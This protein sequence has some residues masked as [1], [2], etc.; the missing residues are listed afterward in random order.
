M[1]SAR[2]LLP[3]L[4]LLGAF[5]GATAGAARAN[6][7]PTG[8]TLLA[9]PV[10]EDAA[11]GA[12]IGTL[13]ATDPDA[14]DTHVFELID[15]PVVPLVIDGDRLRLDGALDYE[16]LA[17]V[18]VAV[19]ARDQGGLAYEGA[20]HFDVL[21]VNEPPSAVTL[22][23][24][25]VREGALPGTVVGTL[26]AVDEDADEAWSFSL[27]TDGSVP[28]RL[29]AG[30]TQV[31]VSRALDFETAPAWTL[32]VTVTDRGGN[33][34][35]LPLLIH[36]LDDPEAPT[37]IAV[38]PGR[39]A[40]DAGSGALVGDVVVT[41]PDAGDHAVV[42]LLDGAGGAVTLSN[43]QIRLARTVDH[44]ATPTLTIRLRAVDTTGRALE[45]VVVLLVDDVNEPP[46]GLTLTPSSVDEG[47]AIGS[48]V[49]LLDSDD[50]DEGDD[51][52]Y[53]LAQNDG[54]HLAVDGHRLIVAKV[55]DYEQSDRIHIR[56]RAVDRGGL[57][58]E[59]SWQI[60]VRDVNEPPTGIAFSPAPVR[61]NSPPHQQLGQPVA[62][63]DPDR[64][65]HF[66]WELVD[67]AGGAFYLANNQL[68]TARSLDYEARPWLVTLRV[69]DHGGLS[70]ERELEVPVTDVN[71]PPTDVALD[72]ASVAENEPAGA[73]V[74]ALAPVGDPDEGDLW[75]YSLVSTGGGRFAIDGDRLVT[76]MALDHEAPLNA[77]TVRVRVTDRGGLSAER[78]FDVV[79]DDVNEPPTGVGVS[80]AMVAENAPIGSSA[81]TLLALGDPDFGDEHA[82]ELLDDA[83]AFAVSG[84]HLVTTRALDF[85]LEPALTL[86]VRCTDGAGHAVEGAVTVQVGDVNE[87]PLEVA[88]AGGSV[89]ENAPAGTVVGA[90]TTVGDPDVGEV[91]A[92]S[93]TSDPGLAF[94][95][96]GSELVTT[97]PLDHEA[98]ATL[99][100]GVQAVDHGGLSVAGRF[101]VTVLDRNDPPRITRTAFALTPIDEDALDSPG[102]SV[103]AVLTHLG[104]LDDDG[105]GALSGVA[106]RAGSVAGGEV[107][108][109]F[110]GGVWRPLGADVRVLAAGVGTRLRFAPDAD[111]NGTLPAA[112]V[113]W[114]WDGTAAADGDAL[115]DVPTGV[116][117]AF[118]AQAAAVGVTVVAID[119]APVV[120]APEDPVAAWQHV[121]V[122]FGASVADVDAEELEVT[123][124]AE[125]GVV[126][127]AEAPGALV[128][129][130]AQ[131]TASVTLRGSTEALSAALARV[132]FEPAAGFVGDAVVR[133]VA[134]DLGGT[135]LGGPLVTTRAVTIAVAAAP[136]V[137]LLR[138]EA[139][140]VDGGIDPLGTLPSGVPLTLVYRLRNVGAAP[141]GV[142]AIDVATASTS[143][144]TA[145]VTVAPPAVVPPGAEGTV[146]VTVVPAGAGPFEVTLAF[147][148][149][150][151]DE[152]LT[153]IVARGEAAPAALLELTYRGETV[154][155][156]VTADLGAF[157]VAEEVK[158]L[159]WV[160]NAGAAVLQLASVRVDAIDGCRLTVEP[161][162]GTLSPGGEEL[163]RARVRAPRAGPF[164]FS[165]AIESNDPRGVRRF[166]LRGIAG[167][168]GAVRIGVTRLPG[169]PIASGG[170][171]DVGWLD[172]GGAPRSWTWRIANL[173]LAPVALEAPVVEASEGVTATLSLDRR[174][175]AP[176]EA[177]S[178]SAR[179]V[180]SAAGPVSV[181]LVVPSANL[182]PAKRLAWT[183]TGE[184][185]TEAAARPRFWRAGV[186]LVGGVDDVGAAVIG[187]PLAVA[188]VL[189]NAG[190]AA[191]AIDGAARLEA[192]EG[193][194]GRVPASP[195][196]AL[197]PGAA[198]MV[199]VE[200]TPAARGALGATLTVAGSGGGRAEVRLEGQGLDAGV[201]L[202]F[203]GDVV[204]D[205]GASWALPE[206]VS[207][208]TMT[209]AVTV[210]NPGVV[211]LVVGAPTW[212]GGAACAEAAFVGAGGGGATIA[213]GE[214][215]ELAL[216]VVAGDGPFAC[217]LGL[218]T[219]VAGPDGVVR[220]AVSGYGRAAPRGGGGGCAG[221]GAGSG[222]WL[223]LAWLALGV[224]TR[225]V[226][227]RGARRP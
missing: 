43:G 175:L 174:A 179:L 128:V 119:D 84:A 31:S 93:I 74:G 210:E 70:F 180:A 7:P 37:A 111:W 165:L 50:P 69:T 17:S 109:R 212:E 16:A 11:P 23:A 20:V 220:V 204:V 85:E 216:R 127:A 160:R 214:S 225:R 206:L 101:T 152:P 6:A 123:L 88:L 72:H 92:L 134:D 188:Y 138:G 65:E 42:S 151:P 178:L 221:G 207:G 27:P 14:G 18:T 82:F 54:E 185:T 140:F 98:E 118:S 200:L 52:Y 170:V 137:E 45:Q 40:E 58:V 4:A 196:G 158:V 156:G 76:T 133:I 105:P 87:P 145:A 2:R 147:P 169:V 213:P 205:N 24:Y 110:H 51:P 46:S 172:A 86:L 112:L 34:A 129:A 153:T 167:E 108:L 199:E 71:E 60:D 61:E 30:G 114:A 186:G 217:V 77:F 115:A 150:D 22:S 161:P 166:S 113:A 159:L 68:V 173:G 57:S 48:F 192:L 79:V 78:D 13:L 67:D 5:L 122:G 28:F 141:L 26:G 194:G 10:P 99:E 222:A 9:A 21:D 154:P 191:F 15:D 157:P 162:F 136:D 195:R 83:G 181:R 95:L 73:V 126:S 148:T 59:G 143:G 190:T 223:G 203:D 182:G 224:M 12:I 38:V 139:S 149:D 209:V 124:E 168:D 193:C 176:G 211:D 117:S 226:M 177:A 189:E 187:A 3:A 106:V 198:G 90:L 56:V 125:R 44:E 62:T 208:D 197:A 155:S 39:V 100:V 104:V 215:A 135:G 218:E 116:D 94:A 1:R 132:R 63:G 8:V 29:T 41:D 201:R 64:Q 144:T 163:V 81:G 55:I 146:V 36:V 89:L 47:G 121:P 183:V 49:A 184:A 171:D 164:S 142:G 32:P 103:A 202:L 130:G 75:T 91:I 19:R 97:R 53:V 35:V 80:G 107:Q 120:T 25:E 227:V 33:V 219:N 96:V 102:D 66:T 131:G